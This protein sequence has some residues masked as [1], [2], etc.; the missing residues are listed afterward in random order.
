MRAGWTH[1]LRAALLGALLATSAVGPMP[2]SAQAPPRPAQVT[3][4]EAQQGKVRVDA[5]VVHANNSGKVDPQLVELKRKFQ[6][7][8]YTGF[9]VLSRHNES[10]SPGQSATVSVAGG[11]R[12]KITF[13]EARK[14]QARVRIQIFKAQS[15]VLD[16]TVQIPEAR[17]FVVA[18]PSYADGILI[19]PITVSF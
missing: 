2:A 19:F 14:S 16:T 5:M 9:K 15:K 12:V 17:Y 4:S 18:G 1:K 3:V 7:M 11:R 13:I 10:M 8:K 6:H